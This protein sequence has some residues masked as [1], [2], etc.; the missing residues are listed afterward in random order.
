MKKRLVIISLILIALYFAIKGFYLYYYNINNITI[1]DYNSFSNNLTIKDTMTIKSSNVEDDNYLRYKNIYV[2][3][4]FNDFKLLENQA[5]Q[6]NV[7]Y[8]LYD[9]DNNLKASFWIGITNSY[10]DMLKNDSTLFGTADKR[11]TNTNLTDI[12]EKN[13][14]KNDVELFKYLSENKNK[15]NT[16]FTPIKQM[17]ENYT[18]QFMISVAIPQ[19]DNITIIDGDYQGYIFNMKNTSNISSIYEARINYNSLVYTFLFLNKGEEYFTK[20]DINNI[21]NTVKFE[22]DKKTIDNILTNISDISLTGATITITDNNKIPYIYG[23]WYK[24]EKEENG[25]WEELEPVAKNYGFNDIAYEVNE[26][27]EIKFVINWENL[28]G[29]LSQGSYRI[30]KEVNKEYIYIPFDIATT[31]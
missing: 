30:V 28:Y 13:N 22:D 12:L 6:D 7:K 17:K 27:H 16:I 15:K 26:N 29:N 3:N 23:E 18:L 14:I 21:L 4:V 31:S 5:S 9:E 20:Q 10:V 25:K 19:I 2:E 24:I 8:V 11:I 1:E